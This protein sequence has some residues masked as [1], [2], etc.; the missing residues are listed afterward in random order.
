MSMKKQ[1]E[2]FA[3]PVTRTALPFLLT[4]SPTA[5]HSTF[6]ELQ[7]K[8][9]VNATSHEVVDEDRL[10]DAFEWFQMLTGPSIEALSDLG[11]CAFSD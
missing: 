4:I 11:T 1:E 3:T 9:P 10:P 6:E 2:D 7:V 8:A 5:P